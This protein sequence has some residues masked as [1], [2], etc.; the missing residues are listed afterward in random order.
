MQKKYVAFFDSGIGGLNL[1]AAFRKKYPDVP[2]LYY[3]DNV[4]APY[5]NKSREEIC[6]LAFAAFGKI[7]RK[8]VAAA[9]IACNT[10]T[11][12][13]AGQ[14]RAA[15]SF[16]VAGMEPAVRPAAKRGGNVLVLATRA[17]MES[18]R[19]QKLLHRYS[20]DARFTLY[21]PQDLAGE[22]ER[23]APDFSRVDL[24]FLPKGEFSAVVLG[25]THYVFL[26]DRIS[27][28]LSC[29]V[30]DGILGTADHLYDIANICSKKPQ[31][32]GKSALIFLG[33]AKNRNKTLYFSLF[34][35]KQTFM[36]PQKR[37]KTDKNF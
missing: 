34:Q 19:M 29:P 12:C 24:S 28:T 13:C 21:C 30:F 17:T 15:F 3:G 4:N 36:M 20:Q 9:A 26:K 14:L 35:N 18:E 33:K 37:T 11:A 6:S 2:C 25:C 31:K 5:G 23:T 27:E 7:A 16:P 22:I 1:L 10:V 8:P 32:R